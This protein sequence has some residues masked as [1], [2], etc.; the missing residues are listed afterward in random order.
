MDASFIA[1]YINSVRTVFATMVRMD[2]RFG[3]PRACSVA[4]SF[5]IS[6]II[7][8]SGDIAGSVALRMN[9]AVAQAVVGRFAGLSCGVEEPDFL[10]AMGELVNIVSGAAK[11]NFDGKNV[12]ISTPSV[13]VGAGHKIACPARTTCVTLPCL[14]ECGEFV[15][16]IAIRE[17]A[18][19]KAA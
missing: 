17:H 13:V 14:L 4:Q 19:A 11:A 7:G 15:L 12:S 1:H 2:V 8:M 5:D 9:N 18:P 16:D 3:D 6:G 10:D